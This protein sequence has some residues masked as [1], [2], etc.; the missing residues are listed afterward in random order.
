MKK[1]LRMFKSFIARK[2]RK[3]TKE[4]IQTLEK[5]KRAHIKHKKEKI[6]RYPSKYSERAKET[7]YKKLK[8]E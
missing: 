7:L 3:Q 5:R 2:K 1:V 4:V 6:E 8:V